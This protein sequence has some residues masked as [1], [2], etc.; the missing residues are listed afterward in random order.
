[1]EGGIQNMSRKD[2]VTSELVTS[3]VMFSSRAMV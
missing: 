1:M 2:F 3:S